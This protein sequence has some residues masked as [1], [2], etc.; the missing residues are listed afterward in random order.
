MGP[1]LTGY[2]LAAAFFL[3]LPW[4]TRIN[5][6]LQTDEKRTRRTSLLLG[7][8]H[9]TG[10]AFPLVGF[11]SSWGT[12]IPLPAAWAA[13]P[14]MSAA[15][16]LQL[17]SQRSLGNYFTMAL[18]SSETQPLSRIGPYRWIRHPA[19]AAQIVFWIALSV[20]S[21]CLIAAAILCAVTAIG[22]TARIRAEEAVMLD[23][24]GDRYRAYLT[25]TKR[26]L[27]LLW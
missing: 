23:S 21:R 3:M 10:L 14:V 4:S 17:W 11:V 7:I 8:V 16:I 5:P 6:R 1:L 13:V 26:L 19:Y 18:Q 9:L 27:P 12:E 22:Y 25:T 20:A 15:L 2:V 24:L